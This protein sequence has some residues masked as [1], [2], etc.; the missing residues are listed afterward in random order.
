M[1]RAVLKRTATGIFVATLL[2]GCDVKVPEPV[3]PTQKPEQPALHP[4]TPAA[5]FSLPLLSGGGAITLSEQK[6]KVVLLDFWATW[7]PPCRYELPAL[8]KMYQELK[9]QGFVVVGMT[10]DRGAPDS[11]KTA[12]DKFQLSYPL[13]LA[14]EKVQDT[15]GGIRAVPTKFLINRKGEIAQTYLGVVPDRQL[16]DDVLAVLAQ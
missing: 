16:R 8:N 15:F 14:D 2:A 12:V 11:I 10:V 6:G 4:A 1:Q 5:D 3:P 13:T 9:E 7:C